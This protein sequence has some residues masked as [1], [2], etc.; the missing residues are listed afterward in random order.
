MICERAFGIMSE[1]G[2]ALTAPALIRTYRGGP[3]VS[4]ATRKSRPG[5]WYPPA[6]QRFWMNTECSPNCWNWTG[7]L[8]EGGYGRFTVD[9]RRV[10][11]HRYAFELLVGPIPAG[12]TLDHLCRNR[13]CVNPAH[14]EPVTR[15]E[16]TRR[17]VR[18][19]IVRVTHCMYGHEYTDE[20]TYWRGKRRACRACHALYEK[21][22]RA[23]L[24]AAGLN[25]R[26]RPYKRVAS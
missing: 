22:R 9:D 12:L 10:L 7:F 23:E 17:G 13:A 20:N 26:S 21:A 5:R 8:N 1:P 15:A 14:L 24:R 11:A 19:V 4:N 18:P 2:A 25:S 3:N 16:N 6:Q